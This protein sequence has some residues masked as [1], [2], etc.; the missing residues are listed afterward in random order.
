M[1]ALLVVRAGFF[2]TVQD[3]GR[4]GYRAQGVSFSGALDQIAFE[5][6]NTLAGNHSGEAALEITM[7]NAAFEFS[8]ARRF[9]IAGANFQ[10]TLDGTPVPPWSSRFAEARQQ[11]VLH[12]PMDGARA[13]IAIAG[14]VDVPRVLGSRSTDV[15]AGFG[16]LD[17][18]PLRSGDHLALGERVR[19][20]IRTPVRVKPPQWQF[21][22]TTFGVLRA[23]EY[24]RFGS[25]A[26]ERFW[27]DEWV[28]TPQSDRMGLRL[29][30][31]ALQFGE[32]TLNSHAVF[33]GVIQVP[34]SGQ[35]IVL[36]NDAQ[37]TGGY[38][39]IG[40]VR[41]ADLWKLAQAQVGSRLRFVESTLAEAEAAQ[42]NVER[43]VEEVKA[44][45][46]GRI[47]NV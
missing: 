2:S 10:A 34:P 4:F 31:D 25:P 11:L 7:G 21:D 36:L 32:G 29:S 18:R 15:R 47:G 38:P 3:R 41:K 9:A 27:I 33:P 37:T 26:Q 20:Q 30:G 12:E 1:S 16:G 40:I 43:Y 17:G 22:T 45:I 28:I 8:D 5:I 19:Q 39:K 35:P 44:A 24:A 42:N 14:G 23:P 13:V 46:A 6:A